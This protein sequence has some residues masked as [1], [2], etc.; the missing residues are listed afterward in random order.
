MTNEAF[1]KGM[2]KKPHRGDA[3]PAELRTLRGAGVAAATGHAAAH[4]AAR[5]PAR[6]HPAHRWCQGAL[7]VGTRTTAA[8]AAAAVA[9]IAACAAC[10]FFRA[11]T[12]CTEC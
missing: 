3:G 6:R 2:T 5:P 10:A 12:N 7:L 1:Q 11:Q 4:A 8:A 9:A